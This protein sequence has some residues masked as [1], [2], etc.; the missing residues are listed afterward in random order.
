MKQVD[1][2]IVF[3]T[4]EFVGLFLVQFSY[5]FIQVIKLLL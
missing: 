2:V 4:K 5:K 1:A 3:T